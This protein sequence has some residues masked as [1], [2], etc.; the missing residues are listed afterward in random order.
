MF[1]SGREDKRKKYT[2]L[3]ERMET[4]HTHQKPRDNNNTSGS[5]TQ[6]SIVNSIWTFD[7]KSHAINWDYL[8]ITEATWWCYCYEEEGERGGGGLC[9][10]F[11]VLNECRAGRGGAGQHCLHS[12]R[13]ERGK[14]EEKAMGVNIFPP[15]DSCSRKRKTRRC[16][17]FILSS[18]HIFLPPFLPVIII[19]SLDFPLSCCLSVNPSVTWLTCGL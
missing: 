12:S 18:N 19:I 16:I 10:G 6:R 7:N 13:G 5:A 8:G 11:P 14:M 1:A 9:A 3:I 15:P 2:C 4:G 17:Q